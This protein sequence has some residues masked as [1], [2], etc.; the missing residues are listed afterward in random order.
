MVSETNFTSMHCCCKP[1]T[2]FEQSQRKTQ[3]PIVQRSPSECW[4][5]T[6]DCSSRIGSGKA[7]QWG[8]WKAIHPWRLADRVVEVQDI[9]R[10]MEA[11]FNHIL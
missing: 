4:P 3:H 8:S 9:S 7:I 10:Q 1:A 2:D 11:S 5:G 6:G